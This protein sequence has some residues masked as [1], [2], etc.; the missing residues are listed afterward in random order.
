MYHFAFPQMTRD[1]VRALAILQ[2]LTAPFLISKAK[3][4][5]VVAHKSRYEDHKAIIA[6]YFSQVWCGIGP[7]LH[8]K[9]T[10]YIL[11]FHMFSFKKN[12]H[13]LTH[14]YYMLTK[15]LLKPTIFIW[16]LLRR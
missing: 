6:T 9:Y 8:L 3:S 12:I 10:K 2:V 5:M 14:A 1:K 15:S 11:H 13:T 4:C 16:Q 7:E